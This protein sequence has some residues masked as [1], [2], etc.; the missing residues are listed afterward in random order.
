MAPSSDGRPSG[1]TSSTSP[2]QRRSTRPRISAVASAARRSHASSKAACQ[3]LPGGRTAKARRRT[4][5][6]ARHRRRAARRARPRALAP[7]GGGRC[8]PAAATRAAPPAE[9][10][11]E[12]ARGASVWHRDTGPGASGGGRAHRRRRRRRGHGGRRAGDPPGSPRR[13]HARRRPL[14]PRNADARA[15]VATARSRDR[16]ADERDV[17]L[18]P[19]GADDQGAVPETGRDRSRSS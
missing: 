9:Q 3:A 13:S 7:V 11:R 16:G 2:E 6:S 10:R 1:K 19:M 8:W 5:R 18:G 15:G 12:H 14:A 17:S 4:F